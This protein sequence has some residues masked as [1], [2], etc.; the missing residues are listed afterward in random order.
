MLEKK[1]EEYLNL[2]KI[3]EKIVYSDAPWEIK[4][5]FIFSEEISIAANKLFRL[6]YYDP[7]TS[8]EEDVLA[9]FN[10]VEKQAAE[11]KLIYEVL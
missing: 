7:D 11:L 9:W 6:D 2:I 3:A 4:Y 5:E 10:A 8:Y 1:I